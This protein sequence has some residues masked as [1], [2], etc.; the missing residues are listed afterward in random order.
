MPLYTYRCTQ[1]EEST[2]KIV[3]LADR[4]TPK[5]CVKC[6]TTDTMIYEPYTAGNKGSNLYFRGNWFAN[7]GRY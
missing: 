7:K 4:E 5:P 3:K 6:E 2:D 1:C